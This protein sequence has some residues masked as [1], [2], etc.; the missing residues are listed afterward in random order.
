MVTPMPKQKRKDPPSS[1]P[2]SK[3]KDSSNTP[4]R[5]SHVKKKGKTKDDSPTLLNLADEKEYPPLSFDAIPHALSCSTSCCSHS[6][7]KLLG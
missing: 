7:V 3:K 5:G 4:S 1:P 2:H 6:A